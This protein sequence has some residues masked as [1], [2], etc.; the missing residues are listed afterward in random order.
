MMAEVDVM[1]VGVME[2]RPG[3]VEATTVKT[4]FPRL[5][6]GRPLFFQATSSNHPPPTPT[7]TIRT[8]I[9]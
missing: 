6:R 9:Y 8:M 2:Y 5:V 3:V 4:V 7:C 1:L